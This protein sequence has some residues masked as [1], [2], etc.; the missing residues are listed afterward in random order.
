MIITEIEAI[1]KGK[2]LIKRE[3]GRSLCLYYREKKGLA[4]EVGCD[5]SDEQWQMGVQSVFTRGKKRVFHLLA[6]KDYTSHEIMKK[7]SRELY[8][9]EIAADILA[10]FSGLGYIDDRRYVEKY[11]T[12][13]KET[14]SRRVIEHKLAQKGVGGGL[15]KEVL[16]ELIGDEDAYIAAKRLGEKKYGTKVL[17]KEEFPKMVQFLMRKGFDYGLSKRVVDE[18]FGRDLED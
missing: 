18:L 1:G 9:D 2:Y 4:M 16:Q 6:K 17:K 12:Y 14:K 3:D 7:L 5:I 8:D 10:Y 11:Y 15:M 13:Y